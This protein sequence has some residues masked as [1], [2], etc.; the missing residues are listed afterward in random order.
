MP[1]IG[2][3]EMNLWIAGQTEVKHEYNHKQ[4]I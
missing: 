2:F 3:P 1:E 4:T